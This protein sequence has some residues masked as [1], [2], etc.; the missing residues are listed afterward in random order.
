MASRPTVILSAFLLK[1]GDGPGTPMPHDFSGDLGS[2]DERLPDDQTSITMNQS[3]L[4]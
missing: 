3:N 1:D 2:F 4:I